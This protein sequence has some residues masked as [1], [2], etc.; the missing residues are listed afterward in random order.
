MNNFIPKELK[1]KIENII[2]SLEVKTFTEDLENKTV[3][4][5]FSFLQDFGDL[6]FLIKNILFYFLIQF[7]ISY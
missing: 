4:Q 2:K 3:T 6:F 1:D 7:N 5:S